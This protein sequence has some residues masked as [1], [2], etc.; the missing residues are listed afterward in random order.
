MAAFEA[1]LNETILG[2]CLYQHLDW[3]GAR[4][5]AT[6]PLLQKYR[7]IFRQLERPEPTIDPD[8][9]LAVDLRNEIAHHLPYLTSDK[10]WLPSSLQGLRDR[11]LLHDYGHPE[12]GPPFTQMLFSYALAYW[13]WE[14]VQHAVERLVDTLGDA[15][16]LAEHTATNFG[17][18]ARICPPDCLA[19]YDRTRDL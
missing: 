4:C 14:V 11:G 2:L 6:R 8:L 15:R 7:G 12:A 10:D 3:P 16:G 19:D 9:A 18:Y 13:C 5:L 17:H 1:W